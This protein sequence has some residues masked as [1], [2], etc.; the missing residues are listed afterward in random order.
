[1][2]IALM[3]CKYYN[4]CKTDIKAMLEASET[5]ACCPHSAFHVSLMIKQRHIDKNRKFKNYLDE[6]HASESYSL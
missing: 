2:G 3:N 5:Y 4:R 6:L 1:M